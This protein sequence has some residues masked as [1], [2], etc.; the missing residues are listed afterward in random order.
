MVGAFL[1]EHRRTGARRH[2]ERVLAEVELDHRADVRA[3]ELTLAERKRLE[4]ARA[5]AT[6]PE[7]LLLDE[8]MAGLNATEVGQ[9]I[10]LIRRLNRGGLTVLLIEHNLKVVR[11]LAQRV[12]VLDHGAP[13]AEGSP[14][15]VL[16]NPQV[17]TAYLG[18][19]RT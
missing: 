16:A 9:A 15:E 12:L 14:D 1:R 7:L 5:L 18:R 3:S 13:I 8:V 19:T 2:A 10:E 17:V 11:A 6:R 4:V